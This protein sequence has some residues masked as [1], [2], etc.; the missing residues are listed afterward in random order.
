M[1]SS[2]TTVWMLVMGI[3]SFVLSV[4]DQS[5]QGGRKRCRPSCLAV[6]AAYIQTKINWVFWVGRFV[7]A[8]LLLAIISVQKVVHA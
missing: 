7:L 5:I 1:L 4:I 8:M 2:K 3:V 6:S